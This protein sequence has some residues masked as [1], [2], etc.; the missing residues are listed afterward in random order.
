M[1]HEKGEQVEETL[2]EMSRTLGRTPDLLGTN[3]KPIGS[4]GELLAWTVL[5]D[6]EEGNRADE[7]DGAKV[8]EKHAVG[9]DLLVVVVADASRD[10]DGN[11]VGDD[12]NGRT[13][14]VDQVVELCC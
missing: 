11:G 12:D 9:E 3:S 1:K 6:N 14:D 10:A 4:F 5:L 2:V 7:G 8:A 13:G